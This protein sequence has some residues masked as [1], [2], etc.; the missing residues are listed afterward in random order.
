M[1][2]HTLPEEENHVHV[3]KQRSWSKVFGLRCFGPR[4]LVRGNDPR[5]LVKGI[6]PKW[7]WFEVFIKDLSI[8]GG[9]HQ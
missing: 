8:E 3:G 2:I 1:H 7:F 6:G 9:K 4:Y 5:Y